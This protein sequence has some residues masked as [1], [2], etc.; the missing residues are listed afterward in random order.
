MIIHRTKSFKKIGTPRT[1]ANRQFQW[2]VQWM[3]KVLRFHLSSFTPPI[4]QANTYKM[5]TNIEEPV[6]ASAFAA[7]TIAAA[8]IAAAKDGSRY[9]SFIQC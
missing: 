9:L 1:Q 6:G 4:L 3:S 7:A 2:N 8:A 5:K